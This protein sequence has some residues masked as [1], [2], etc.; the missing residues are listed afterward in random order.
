MFNIAKLIALIASVSLL[1]DNTQAVHRSA[2]DFERFASMKIEHLE[3]RMGR[4]E[5]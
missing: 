5:R 3:K 2:S 4:L 1:A